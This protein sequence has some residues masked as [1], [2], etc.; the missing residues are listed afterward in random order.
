MENLMSRDR[1]YRVY[2]FVERNTGTC[3]GECYSIHDRSK[4]HTRTLSLI[5][6]NKLH[7]RYK[8]KTIIKTCFIENYSRLLQT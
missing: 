5:S 2:Q 6:R 3:Y 1:P 7:F 4:Y 8:Y